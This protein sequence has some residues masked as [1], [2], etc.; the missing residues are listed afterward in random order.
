M[1][2]LNTR[3]NQLINVD[4]L[5]FHLQA[6]VFVPYQ[7]LIVA[8]TIIIIIFLLIENSFTKVKLVDKL[9]FSLFHSSKL[10]F[11]EFN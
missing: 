6:D 8:N 4:I 3:C 1:Q 2:I 10:F 7:D 9:I 11:I 5:Q